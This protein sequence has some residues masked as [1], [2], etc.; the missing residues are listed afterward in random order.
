M[1]QNI[2]GKE[3]MGRWFQHVQEIVFFSS[4]LQKAA[5]L[6]GCLF[7]QQAQGRGQS[8]LSNPY[9]PYYCSDEKHH[10]AQNGHL[11]Q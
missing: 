6:S 7:F 4:Y 8:S 1:V 2:S 10:K 3:N 11:N 5:Q 9:C